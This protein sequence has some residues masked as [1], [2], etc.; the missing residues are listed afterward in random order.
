M[1][2]VNQII[3]KVYYDKSGYGSLKTTLENVRKTDKSITNNDIKKFFQENVEQKKQLKGYNSF[4]A[5]YPYYEFQ[6]DLFFLSDLEKQTYKVGM[7]MIDI[8]T[9]Y[10]VVVPIKTKLEGDVISGVIECLN[11]MGGKPEIIYSDDE[12]SLSSNAINEYYIKKDIKHIVTRTH[13][14]F[15]ERAIKTFKQALYKRIDDSK[16]KNI[17]WIDLVYEVILTYNNKL[18]HSSTKFTPSNA[19]L[20][21]NELD[22]RLNLLLHKKHSRIYPDLNEGDKVKIYKKKKVGEKERVSYWSDNNYEVETISKSHGQN[23][24]K[25]IGLT[26]QFLRNELLKI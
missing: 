17:Q 22:V 20:K 13:A 1:Q 7:I 12:G 18:I 9:K 3:S 21:K 26:K 15:A 16:D 19:R 25:I 10:M 5:P 24:F 11:L 4:I 2:N 23:N 6:C 8:F 14:W